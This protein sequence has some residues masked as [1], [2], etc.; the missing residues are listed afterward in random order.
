MLSLRRI[1]PIAL[2]MLAIGGCESRNGLTAINTDC[3]L[4]GSSTG[5]ITG[6]VSADL[7]GCSLFTVAT[8]AGP[9]MTTIGLSHGSGIGATH[10]LSLGREGTRPA[11]GTY[12]IGTAAGNFTGA[13]TF[14]GGSGP[15]RLF[16]LTAGTVTI[17]ASSETTLSGTLSGVTAMETSTPANTI[18][19]NA[20]FSARC[21]VTSTTGC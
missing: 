1:V 19:L 15:N 12:T 11:T 5:S 13:F 21:T 16:A 10:A 6:A 8:G 3:G 2:L 7:N 4:L 20:T 17:T 9:T 14:D 18:T